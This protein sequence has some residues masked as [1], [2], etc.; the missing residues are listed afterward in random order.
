MSRPPPSPPPS[1]TTLDRKRPRQE[2]APEVVAPTDATDNSGSGADAETRFSVMINHRRVF[3]SVEHP[4]LTARDLRTIVAAAASPTHLTTDEERPVLLLDYTSTLCMRR[5]RRQRRLE[6]QRRASEL[7]AERV[8]VVRAS[9]TRLMQRARASVHE[10]ERLAALEIH[11]TALSRRRKDI[12]QKL[13]DVRRKLQA[14]LQE[15]RASAA[16][17]AGCVLML[18]SPDTGEVQLFPGHHYRTVCFV[19]EEL[20]EVPQYRSTCLSNATQPESTKDKINGDGDG[21]A[22]AR[23]SN[24]ARPRWA[25][26]ELLGYLLFRQLTLHPHSNGKGGRIAPGHSGGTDLRKIAAGANYDLIDDYFAL[27]ASVAAMYREW[28]MDNFKS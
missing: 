24:N 9:N 6:L 12:T 18:P 11:I 10:L 23:P 28:A 14:L 21:D 13:L 19:G 8:D 27:P 5:Q 4:F 7:T 22:T 26:A 20:C 16:S 15:K 3:A 25:V 1:P 2:D 17:H